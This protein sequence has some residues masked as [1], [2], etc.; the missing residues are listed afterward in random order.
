MSLVSVRG[1][2]ITAGSTGT[3]NGK[4]LEVPPLATPQL[5][6]CS[7]IDIEYI[8]KFSVCSTWCTLLDIP[9]KIII[10]TVPL[11]K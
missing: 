6:Y 1:G 11:S 2:S 7:I 5:L 9:I 8:L 3:W 4:V 10:G